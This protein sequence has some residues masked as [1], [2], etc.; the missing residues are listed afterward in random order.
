MI[1][2]YVRECY[3]PSIYRVCKNGGEGGS[4]SKQW[5]LHSGESLSRSNYLRLGIC[6]I[7]RFLKSWYVKY[8]LPKVEDTGLGYCYQIK[9]L[10]LNKQ[11]HT[12]THTHTHKGKWST[13]VRSVFVFLP[14]ILNERR[15]FHE[16]IIITPSVFSK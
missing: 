5:A 7:Y 3:V 6:G 4:G 16:K 12:H 14:G 9:V 10:Y 1:E 8:R 15:G 13:A 11:C 2:L